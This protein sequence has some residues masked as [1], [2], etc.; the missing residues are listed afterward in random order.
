MKKMWGPQGKHPPN[1]SD[2]LID[3]IKV[4]CQ[5]HSV[6]YGTSQALVTRYNTGF[7]PR[8]LTSS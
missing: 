1:Q 8:L 5:S 7:I 6:H 4:E 3:N 2:D